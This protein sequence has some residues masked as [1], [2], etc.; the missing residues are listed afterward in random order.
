LQDHEYCGVATL[1]EV[2]GYDAYD[3]KNKETS[4]SIRIIHDQANPWV[5]YHL[6]NLIGR[7]I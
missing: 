3:N 4:S 6:R 2:E 5:F 1:C 7:L